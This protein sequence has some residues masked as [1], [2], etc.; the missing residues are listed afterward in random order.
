M[1]SAL[2][3]LDGSPHSAAALEIAIQFARRHQ[4]KLYGMGILDVPTIT[5]SEAVPL[6]A[7]YFKREKED[8]LLVDASLAIQEF[9]GEFAKTC[10]AAGVEYEKVVAKGAP[11]DEICRESHR[12]DLIVMA[13]ESHYHFETQI[14][15]DDIFR[16]IVRDTPRP[17]LAVHT[18]S[19][20]NGD[21]ILVAYDGSIQAAR[22]L[23]IHCALGLCENLPVDVLTV[24]S[25]A[26]HAKYINQHILDY[27]QARGIQANG[28]AMGTHEKPQDVIL[29]KIEELHPRHLV[30]GSYAKSTM[31]EMFFGSATVDL[32]AKSPVP[33]FLFD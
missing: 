2:V 25:D 17:V 30:M 9:L 14:Q 31:A 29:Q 24:D 8:V 7:T 18:N 10:D 23:Q 4:I 5:A 26:A 28:I 16:L 27:Y 33:L 3:P 1:Y 32:L 19:S 21:R 12:H 13:C 15:A 22:T 11:Y 20:Q 6:G